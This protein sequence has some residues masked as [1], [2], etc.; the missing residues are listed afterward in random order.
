MIPLALITLSIICVAVTF[1]GGSVAALR[2]T[3]QAPVT[4]IAI[5]AGLAS[6]ALAFSAGIMW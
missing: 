3:D 2:D 4:W 1:G 5:V 6:T